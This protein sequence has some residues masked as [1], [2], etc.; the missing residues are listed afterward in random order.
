MFFL[1]IFV[2]FI[3]YIIIISIPSIF[4]L[5]KNKINKFLMNRDYF[6]FLHLLI[7]TYLFFSEHFIKNNE[8]YS[9]LIIVFIF[10]PTILFSGKDINRLLFK[11]S[12]KNLLLCL[13]LK[14]FPFQL[15]SY[16]FDNKIKLFD[17]T[18]IPVFQFIFLL[19][20]AILTASLYLGI[21]HSLLFIVSDFSDKKFQKVLVNI[22]N[23]IFKNEKS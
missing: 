2:F 22:K 1:Y 9:D 4:L 8:M 10:V 5:F 17:E 11:L 6:F 12:L 13:S 15:N 20:K 21:T 19:I 16:A 7:T 23:K 3:F 14:Y 18:G